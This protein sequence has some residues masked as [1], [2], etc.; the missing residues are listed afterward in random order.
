MHNQIEVV[1]QAIPLVH[2]AFAKA[3]AGTAA[4]FFHRTLRY[5]FASQNHFILRQGYGRQA[6]RT[7]VGAD[8]LVCKKELLT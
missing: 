7:V 5:N 1:A 4:P 6:G 3:T 2:P 8:C